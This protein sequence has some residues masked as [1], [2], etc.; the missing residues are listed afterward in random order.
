MTA[1]T[2]RARRVRRPR[3]QEG[4]PEGIGALSGLLLAAS[5]F[6]PWYRPELGEVFTPE[7]ASGWDATVVARIVFV[8]ALALTA[9]CGAL[10]LSERGSIHLSFDASDL[11]SWVALGAAVLATVLVLFRMVLVPEPSDLLS[12]DWG[13]FLALAASVGALVSAIAL[14]VVHS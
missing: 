14:R 9:S 10:V 1:L 5:V 4:A 2:D 3:F 7:T 6:A 12:R 13:L 11:A 8:L